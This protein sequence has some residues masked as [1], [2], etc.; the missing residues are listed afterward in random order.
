MPPCDMRVM[1]FANG[2]NFPENRGKVSYIIRSPDSEVREYYAL[3]RHILF[4]VGYSFGNCF[5][6]LRIR[7][8][9]QNTFGGL[10]KI[11]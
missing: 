9:Q 3:E 11:V 2:N 10:F 4:A 1:S 6:V 8:L 7:T 5:S